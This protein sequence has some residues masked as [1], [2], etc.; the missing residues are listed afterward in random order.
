MNRAESRGI[1]LPT[2]ALNR[3]EVQVHTS[4]KLEVGGEFTL[5]ETITE[6]SSSTRALKATA[7]P[8]VLSA[9]IVAREIV[10]CDSGV[11]PALQLQLSEELPPAFETID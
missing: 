2:A 4:G 5:T 8:I 6:S 9:G 11:E 1:S 3:T 7:R 10:V